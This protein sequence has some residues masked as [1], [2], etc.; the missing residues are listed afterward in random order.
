MLKT[1]AFHINILKSGFTKS[2]DLF[3]SLS[4]VL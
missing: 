3:S 2:V 4:C 1:K